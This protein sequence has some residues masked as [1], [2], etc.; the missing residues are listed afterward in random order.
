M[1][2][3]GII[4]RRIQIFHKIGRGLFEVCLCIFGEKNFDF[5]VSKQFVLKIIKTCR[6]VITIHD[7]KKNDKDEIRIILLKLVL[8]TQKRGPIWPPL[9]PP[10]LFQT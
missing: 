8:P 6:G 3:F 1:K 4:Q 9:D 5:G 10:M 7:K 2:I